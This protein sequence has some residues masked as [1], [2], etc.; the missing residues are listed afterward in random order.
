MRDVVDL[1]AVYLAGNLVADPEVRYV[2]SGDAVAN[3]RLAVNRRWRSQTG[4]QREETLFVTVVAWGRQAETCGEYLRKGS[5]VLVEGW[6]QQRS[7]ETQEGDKRSVVE[8]RARRI[9]FLGGR[10][11][12]PPEEIDESYEE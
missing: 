10:G 2:P 3:L 7:W 4:E 5:P 8:V 9:Q 11:A 6:L 12:A 1:N